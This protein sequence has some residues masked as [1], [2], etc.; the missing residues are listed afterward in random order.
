[1]MDVLHTEVDTF[2]DVAI[3]DDLVYDHTDRRETDIVY[4]SSPPLDIYQETSDDEQVVGNSPVIVFVGAYPF[5][6]KH[7]P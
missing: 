4:N 2:F 7:W 1:M 5:V 3:A 6:E